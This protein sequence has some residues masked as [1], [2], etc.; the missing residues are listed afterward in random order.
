MDISIILAAGEG[1]RMKSKMPKVLHKVCGKPILEYVIDA[2]LGAGI[3]KNIVIVGH[4]GD[5]IKDFFKEEPITFKNQPLGKDA[6]YGTGFAVM[7]AI[8]EI[9]DEDTVVILCGDT[10]LITEK[11]IKLLLDYHKTEG[12]H[13]TVLTTLLDD[14]TGYGRIKR[15]VYGKVSNIVEEK[16]ATE[17]EKEIKEINSGVFC[18]NGK[19]LRSFLKKLDNNNAQNEYY[20]TDIIGILKEEGYSLGAVIIEDKNEIHGVNSR[21]QLSFSEKLMKSRINNFHMR[22][23]VTIIDPE[24]T[25]IGKNVKIGRDTVIYPGVFLEG[26]TNIG[27]DCIIRGNTR[28]FNSDIESFVKIE[29]S[30]IEDSTVEMGASL[31]P[32]AHLRPKSYIG[33]NVHIGNFVE[34]KNARIGNNSKAGHL[35]Y[36]GDAIVGENVNI[37]CGVIFANYNGIE[38][39]QTI[40]GDNCFI[41]SNSNLVAPVKIKDWGYV[42]AGSTI[43]KEVEEGSLSIER[44]TQVNIK[45]WVERKGLKNK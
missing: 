26:D 43:T 25:Y 13:G 24:N 33:K 39:S 22:E 2:S 3:E 17:L 4:G 21:E 15:D 9:K 1:T 23:G 14:A 12:L 31:G 5:I 35:A 45:G 11:S 30:V 41:G 8:E 34:V 28:V 29:G 18:F 7:Q 19:V 10:P 42:A 27:E 44:A 38:K 16:D 37:G 6:P 20:I 36:I 40:V 32:N